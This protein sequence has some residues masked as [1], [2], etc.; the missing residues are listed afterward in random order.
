MEIDELCENKTKGRTNISRT[1]LYYIKS[2]LNIRNRN[3]EHNRRTH[4]FGVLRFYRNVIML[5]L[6]SS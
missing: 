1:V 6:F 2:I 4:H 3:V 5:F